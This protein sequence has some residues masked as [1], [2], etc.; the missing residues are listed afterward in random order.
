MN[1]TPF[2][3]VEAAALAAMTPEER[4]EFD[5]ADTEEEARLQLAEL[6]Y[7][8]RTEAGL[9]QAALAARVGTRQSTISAIEN[10]AQIPTFPMLNRIAN[11]AGAHLDV[12]MPKTEEPMAKAS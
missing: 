2:R 3:E 5:A 6:V 1:T 4:A 8:T 11:A 10:G 9:T 12:T 7:K